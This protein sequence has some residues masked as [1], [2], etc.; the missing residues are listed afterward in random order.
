VEL[1]SVTVQNVS[2]PD[3]LQKL[4]DQ[5]AGMTLVGADMG[6]F[7][8]Y[9]MGQSLPAMAAGGPAGGATA[10]GGSGVIGD[11]LGLGAGVALGQMFAQ[12]LQGGAG[13]AGPAAA[14]S[15]KPDEVL[16]IIEKLGELQAK[17]LLSAEEF[18]AKKTEL[19]KKLS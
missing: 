1:E 5:R 6:R 13:S 11:A 16:A 8:Q 19:L 4:L 12:Q 3:E 17:G 10:G 7:V 2:L 9:Q 14:P 15:V 18:G